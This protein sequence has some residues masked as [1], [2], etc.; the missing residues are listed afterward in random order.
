MFLTDT[1]IGEGERMGKESRANK[2]VVFETIDNTP[3]WGN[4]KH[5]SVSR[6]DHYPGWDELLAIKDKHFGD[7]DCMMI[8]PKKKDYINLHPF[9]FHIWQCPERW[10]IR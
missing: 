7:I 9:C 2:L 3:K 10:G 1:D 4:L 5:V 8:M 6:S